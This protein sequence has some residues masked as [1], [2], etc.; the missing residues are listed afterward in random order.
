[1][2]NLRKHISQ[3]C[4]ELKRIRDKCELT[5]KMKKNRFW[6]IKEIKG[7]ITIASLTS[8]KE[9]KINAIRALKRQKERKKTAYERFKTNQWFDVD[10]GS[11]YS[12][13]NNIIKST[14]ANHHPQ[15]T[16]K[17]RPPSTNQDATPT[18][19]TTR[20]EFEGFWRPI[21]ESA[22]EVPIEADWVK[23]TET[24]LKQH[25]IHPSGPITSSPGKDK[26]TN[27]WIKKMDT[28]HGDVAA[29]LNTILTERL[30]IPAW[31]TV[32]RSVMI[33]KKDNPSSPDHRPITCLNTLMQAHHVS[34]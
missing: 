22:S 6:M 11:F 1:M 16:G 31:L 14:E 33:P 23:D 15:Y 5:P 30:G 19:I 26:I 3:I 8:L 21:W 28:F 29:A 34:D 18:T 9:R 32:G 4:E 24:A 27:Y 25:I 20:E 12:H 17:E 7:R 13:L 10:E 2:N